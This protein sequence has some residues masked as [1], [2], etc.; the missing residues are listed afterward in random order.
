[1]STKPR[2][3]ELHLALATMVVLLDEGWFKIEGIFY[4]EHGGGTE[5]MGTSHM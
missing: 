1:M 4:C 5:L 2:H 3:S